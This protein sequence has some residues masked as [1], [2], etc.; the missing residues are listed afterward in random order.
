MDNLIKAVY[1]LIVVLFVS[2]IIGQNVLQP[3]YETVEIR[4]LELTLDTVQP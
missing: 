1:G 2:I 3:S 4:D